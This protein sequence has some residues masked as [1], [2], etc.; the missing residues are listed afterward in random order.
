MFVNTPE[1]TNK[2]IYQSAARHS[3]GVNLVYSYSKDGP[4]KEIQVLALSNGTYGDKEEVVQD[5]TDML[6]SN[7][8]EE[9][10]KHVSQPI[11]RENN[12]YKWTIHYGR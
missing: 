8:K 2:I 3:N 4:Y 10:W 5:F 9:K 6:N 7:A 11:D 1:S 12:V